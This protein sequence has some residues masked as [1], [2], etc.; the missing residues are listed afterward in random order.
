MFPTIF[1][2][3]KLLWV[4]C[5]EEKGK[6]NIR[7]REPEEPQPQKASKETIEQIIKRGKHQ[8]HHKGIKTKK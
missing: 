4:N 2:K 5:C 7:K 8:T 6:E 3:L 1:N